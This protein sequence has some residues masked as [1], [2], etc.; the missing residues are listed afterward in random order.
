M[1]ARMTTMIGGT[2]A[3]LALV[4]AAL[5]L[6]RQGGASAFAV[7]A[8]RPE[9]VRWAI[10]GAAVAVAAVGEAIFMGFVVERVYGKSRFGRGL[11]WMMGLTAAVATISAIVLALA[12]S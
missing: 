1:T 4:V 2:L 7:R 3:G 8:D 9:V 6:W 11:Q 12:G 10:A 5:W